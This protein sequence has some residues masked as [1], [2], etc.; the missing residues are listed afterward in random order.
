M[1]TLHRELRF[2]VRTLRLRKWSTGLAVLTAGVAIGATTAVYSTVDWL[3]NRPPGAVIEPHRLVTLRTTDG[4]SDLTFAF[5][6]YEAI[7]RVQD[8]FSDLSAYAKI[9]GVYSTDTRSD[10]VIYEFVTGNYFPMLGVRPAHGRTMMPDDDVPGA[11]PVVLLSYRFWQARFAGDTGV[12]D[13]S[14]TLNGHRCRVIGVLPREFEGYSLDWNGPTSVWL[15]A[16]SF[17]PLFASNMLT[18]IGQGGIFFPLIGRLRPGVSLENAQRRAQ[19]WVPL[20]TGN[21]SD[22]Y[23]PN[24]ILL[25]LSTDTRISARWARDATRSFFGVLLAVCAL[26]LLAACFN[27]ANF[28]IGRAVARRGEIALRTALGASRWRVARPLLLEAGLIGLAA[29]G[30]GIVVAVLL[31]RMSAAMPRIFFR[32]PVTTEA[33]IDTRMVT[34]AIGLGLLS[35]LVFGLIPAVL[36][37]I[38]NPL[39][40]LKNP[41]PGWTWSGIRVSTRQVLLVLQVALSVVLASAAGLY[42]HSFAKIA[43]LDSG[44]A[45]PGQVLVARVVPRALTAEQG[46]LFYGQFLPGLNAMSG[47]VSASIGWNPPYY[48]G[49]NFFSVPG[50][51]AAPIEAGATAAAPR[52]FQT[53]GIRLAAGREFDGSPEELKTGVVINQ[54][55]AERLWPGQSAVG[56]RVLYG[57]ELRTVTGVVTEQRCR[58]L[59]GPP[60]PCSYRPFPTNSP[61]YLRVRVQGDPMAFVPRLRAFIHEIHPEVALAEERTLDAHVRDLTAAQ[62]MSA[63]ATMA[64]ALLGIA[65]LAA[66][67]VSLFVSMVRDSVREIA[68]RMALGASHSHLIRR[69]V[70]QGLAIASVGIAAGLLATRLVAARIADQ[71]YEVSAGDPLTWVLAP[72]VVGLVSLASVYA[73]ALLASRTDP[74]RL[75]RAE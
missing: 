67:C 51:D 31:I 70:F 36:A 55:L 65:L 38:R 42:A 12:V 22:R 46:A 68:I 17:A 40:D 2:A 29:A 50:M 74:A 63:G 15:P 16:Q 66:G 43:A 25:R 69:I 30:V 5:T 24:G 7:R 33:V 13:R 8:V 44:Y 58:D 21:T 27:I 72:A 61:G 19:S 39:A 53:L 60:E 35:A 54:I 49:R 41:K 59:L 64:L 57:Q 11:V 62:R 32:V 10:Q 37:S 26:V 75:L 20:L 14:I 47:V 9:P 71:L 34:V 28:L 18:R 48:I 6:Q 45:A 23:K 4:Q 73:A 3:L 56:Q 52:F 1:A